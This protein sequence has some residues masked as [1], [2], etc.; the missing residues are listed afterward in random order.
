[1]EAWQKNLPT[2]T[3]TSHFKWEGGRS[4]KQFVPLNMLLFQN[5]NTKQFLRDENGW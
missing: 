4:L 5:K 3:Y 2:V 1:M